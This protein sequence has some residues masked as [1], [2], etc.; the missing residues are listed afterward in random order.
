MI[1]VFDLLPPRTIT[2]NEAQDS[3]RYVAVLLDD[4]SHVEARCPM[5][6]SDGIDD[7]R[8]FQ[9]SLGSCLQ[10]RSSLYPR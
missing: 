3:P 1:Y 9:S 4:P 2:T 10:S 8:F 7:R 6:I 5:H